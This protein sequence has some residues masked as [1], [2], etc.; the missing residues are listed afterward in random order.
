M[1]RMQGFLKNLAAL[2]K[3]K[4]PALSS[5]SRDAAYPPGAAV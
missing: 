4:A 2:V 3:V 1:M 5:S